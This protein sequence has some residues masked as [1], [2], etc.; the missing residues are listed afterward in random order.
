[1]VTIVRHHLSTITNRSTT[2]LHPIRSHHRRRPRSSSNISNSNS[3]SNRSTLRTLILPSS[4]SS[5]S[6]LNSNSISSITPDIHHRLVHLLRLGRLFHQSSNLTL[7]LVRRK[8]S[9][10]T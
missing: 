9:R 2:T 1:M 10:T 4:S 3:S 8:S 5:S 6:S 7:Q